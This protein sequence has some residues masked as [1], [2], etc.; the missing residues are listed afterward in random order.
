LIINKQ[1]LPYTKIVGAEA[2]EL[3]SQNG[4]DKGVEIDALIAILCHQPYV[5]AP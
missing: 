2:T 5:E 1:Q 4:E 3:P